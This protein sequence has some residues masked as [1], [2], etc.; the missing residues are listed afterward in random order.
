[1]KLIIISQV[2]FKGD[3]LEQHN[4]N[5]VIIYFDQFCNIQRSKIIEMK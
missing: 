2:E 3:M 5:F 1:M 4:F